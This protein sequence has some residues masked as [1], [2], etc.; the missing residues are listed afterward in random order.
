MYNWE[1]PFGELIAKIRRK[2]VQS[3]FKRALGIAVNGICYYISFK[4]CLMLLLIPLVLLQPDIGEEA[5]ETIQRWNA[6]ALIFGEVVSDNNALAATASSF[7][8]AST[9]STVSTATQTAVTLNM[10]TST[11]ASLIE[12]FATFSLA[13]P[14][15]PVLFKI[16]A[17]LQFLRLIMFHFVP[18]CIQVSQESKITF[19]RIETFLLLPELKKGGGGGEDGEEREDEEEEDSPSSLKKIDETAPAIVVENLT[20]AWEQPVAN[21][22][23]KFE[24]KAGQDGEKAGKGILPRFGSRRKKHNQN[25]NDKTDGGLTKSIPVRPVGEFAVPFLNGDASRNSTLQS[26]EST[27]LKNIS[28]TLNRG[29]LVVVIGPVAAGKS[30]LLASL[31]GEIPITSLGGKLSVSGRVAYV[32]QQPWVFSASI[33]QNVTFGN[34]YRSDRFKRVL[35]ACDLTQ[36]I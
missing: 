28:L 7:V 5:K 23:S 26:R 3:I 20:A 13:V 18:Y 2:E 8:N 25:G 24:E 19:E 16:F 11:K 9:A 12:R 10:T 32:A 14:A 31:L 22:L 21:Q 15:A 29:D 6:S 34:P 27:T 35:Q 4:L 1:K 30:S 33:K 36:V 17:L